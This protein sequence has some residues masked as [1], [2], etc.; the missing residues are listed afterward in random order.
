[1]K[2]LVPVC[3]VGNNEVALMETAREFNICGYVLVKGV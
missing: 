1:M 2:A 3:I